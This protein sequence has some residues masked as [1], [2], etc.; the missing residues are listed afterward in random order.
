[1]VRGTELQQRKRIVQ[2][3]AVGALGAV[4]LPFRVGRAEVTERKRRRREAARDVAMYILSERL[5]VSNKRIGEVFGVT[6]GAVP[7]AAMRAV[8]LISEQEKVK[9][10]TERAVKSIF[11]V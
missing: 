2:D 1:M 10:K 3:E 6:S 11:G 9:D 4:M 8:A 5:G 7:K